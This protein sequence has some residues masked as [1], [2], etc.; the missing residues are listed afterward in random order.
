[1]ALLQLPIIKGPAPNLEELLFI[2]VLLTRLLQC[3]AGKG[4]PLGIDLMG[5]ARVHLLKKITTKGR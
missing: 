3:N 5:R 4:S 2:N 1:M